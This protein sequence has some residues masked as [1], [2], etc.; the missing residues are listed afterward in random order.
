LLI[1]PLLTE[2]LLSILLL[3]PADP[4]LVLLPPTL[5]DLF[6]LLSPHPHNLRILTLALV[7]KRSLIRRS[8]LE[9]SQ[10]FDGEGRVVAAA[11]LTELL[12][13]ATVFGV[14]YRHA[15]TSHRWEHGKRLFR[16][17]AVDKDGTR[18][19]LLIC[20]M[21]RWVGGGRGGAA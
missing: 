11:L 16:S 4:L 19:N 8:S 1:D 6:I 14:K 12:L 5:H 18:R 21:E 20:R 2:Y 3:P 7:T 17:A 13:P 9:P 15:S 10:A